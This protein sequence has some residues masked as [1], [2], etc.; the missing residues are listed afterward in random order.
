MK[1]STSVYKSNLAWLCRIKPEISMK[2]LLNMYVQP[3]EQ[4]QRA[5]S[6][7]HTHS[8]ARAHTHIYI[9]FCLCWTC[10]QTYIACD[11][12]GNEVKNRSGVAG[13]GCGFQSDEIQKPAALGITPVLPAPLAW[14]RGWGGCVEQLT[15]GGGRPL[16]AKSHDTPCPIGSSRQEALTQPT[17]PTLIP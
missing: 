17:A 15:E 7:L 12:W 4:K 1:Y 6:P 11:C 10:N 3:G 5:S 8:Q 13:S 14:G 16:N 9:H 2:F